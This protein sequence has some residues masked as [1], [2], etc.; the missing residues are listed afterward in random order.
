MNRY[1]IHKPIARSFQINVG[2]R[3]KFSEQYIKD[4]VEFGMTESVDKYRGKVIR[5]DR[6]EDFNAVSRVKWDDGYETS[7]LTMNLI[8]E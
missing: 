2:D 1:L 8:H 7:E 3:I 5:M 6:Q 4:A